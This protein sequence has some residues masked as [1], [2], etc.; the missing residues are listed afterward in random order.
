[1][2][3]HRIF[4]RCED[5]RIFNKEN[6][7]LLFAVIAIIAGGFAL[8]EV[9]ASVGA[10]EQGVY[11]FFSRN[12]DFVL[13]FIVSPI[14]SIASAASFVYQKNARNTLTAAVMCIAIYISVLTF[15][16]FMRFYA[17]I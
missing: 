4:R 7:V 15:I 2:R 17:Y 13:G 1:M 10:D 5:M 12:T 3:K 11:F 16:L 6:L 14:C 8:Y 9:D